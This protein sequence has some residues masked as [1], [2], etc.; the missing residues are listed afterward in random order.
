MKTTLILVII[1]VLG[2][3]ALGFMGV[4]PLG[5]NYSMCENDYYSTYPKGMIDAPTTYY[6]SNDREIG[7]SLPFRV[8]FS[9]SPE[10]KL[11]DRVG[12]CTRVS[13]LKF[14]LTKKLHI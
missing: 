4:G 3:F 13:F 1:L 10:K 7:Q 9:G 5:Y 14:F 2:F 6:N 8:A 12:K 11:R